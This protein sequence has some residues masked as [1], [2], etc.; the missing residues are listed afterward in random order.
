MNNHLAEPTNSTDTRLF[1]LKLGGLVCMASLVMTRLATRLRAVTF[2]VS[3]TGSSDYIISSDYF[4]KGVL[5]A[6]EIL[7]PGGKTLP[8]EAQRLPS[9][10]SFW[11]QK[12]KRLPRGSNILP[13]G[14][15]RLKLSDNVLNHVW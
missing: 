3:F 5:H 6:G 1:D 9:G 4:S 14:S 8:P 11:P 12:S 7:L 2:S 13:R 10:S 15:S